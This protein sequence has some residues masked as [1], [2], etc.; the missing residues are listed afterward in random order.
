MEFIITRKALQ[1]GKEQA[2]L[3]LFSEARKVSV[4]AWYTIAIDLF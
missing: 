4:L 2:V 1:Y 3:V